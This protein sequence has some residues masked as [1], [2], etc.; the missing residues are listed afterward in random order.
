MIFAVP[1]PAVKGSTPRRPRAIRGPQQTRIEAIRLALRVFLLG[2]LLAG[3]LGA[4]SPARGRAEGREYEF[5]AA[6]VY[7]F[8]KF[9]DWPAQRLPA[10]SSTINVCVVGK[11]AYRA[12]LETING[13]SVKGKTITVTSY[14]GPQDVSR[15]HILFVGDS[16]TTHLS[17]LLEGVRPAGVLTVGDSSSFAKE[18]GVIRF[19]NENNKIRFDINPR[20]AEE[21]GLTIS[22]QLL[23]LARI[24]Q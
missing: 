23:K 15:C 17:S 14:N 18:G 12:A 19:R 16:E 9:V 20:A 6:Y 11:E 21:S 8:I 10:S 2:V 1:I 5:K 7:N 13:K 3:V 24:V 4:F 22:S